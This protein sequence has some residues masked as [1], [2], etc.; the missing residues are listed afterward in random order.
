MPKK[1]CPR[2]GYGV[3]SLRTTIDSTIRF[4]SC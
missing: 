4:L 2:A 1:F 3:L